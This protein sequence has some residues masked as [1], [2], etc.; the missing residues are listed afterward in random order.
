MNRFMLIAALAVSTALAAC[1]GG[2]SGGGDGNQGSNPKIVAP[3]PTNQPATQPG[4]PPA[5]QPVTQPNGGQTPTP[6]ANQIAISVKQVTPGY[7]NQ[8]T[9]SVTICVPGTTN[10][11]TINNV[12][13]DTGSSGL[14]LF[15]SEVSLALPRVVSGSATLTECSAFGSGSTWG[16]VASAD[17]SLAGEV[18]KSASVQLIADPAVESIPASCMAE[19]PSDAAVQTAAELGANGIIGVGLATADCGTYCVNTTANNVYFSCTASTC[20]QTTAAANMQVANPVG[21]F[22]QDNN[23]VAITLPAVTTAGLTQVTGTLTFG[24]GTQSDNALGTAQVYTVNSSGEVTTIYGS[25]TDTDSFIDSGSNGFF[26][27]D[28]SITQCA[29]TDA[30]GFYC[31]ASTL[32]ES[33]MIQGVNGNNVSVSFQVANTDTIA[34]AGVY[35]VNGLATTAPPGTFDWGLPFFYGRTVYTAINN[36]STP[37]GTGPYFAF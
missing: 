30:P 8:P 6:V 1:G 12:L 2:G 14:R 17:I 37:G 23:G 29:I 36:A 3:V 13:V 16:T 10:C 18:A 20:S 21:Q 33:A 7:F 9:A 35:A 32:T 25:D 24:I 22:A 27:H 34:A 26:F 4:S 31:P 19:S 5:T 11:Q 28:S 15:S